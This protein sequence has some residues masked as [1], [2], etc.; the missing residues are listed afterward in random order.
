VTG[1]SDG[2]VSGVWKETRK[3]GNQ[4][5]HYTDYGLDNV[6]LEGMIQYECQKCGWRRLK[7]PDVRA[8]HFLIAVNL[9]FKMEPLTRHEIGYLMRII[10]EKCWRTVN[11]F[12]DDSYQ[13]G[14]MIF[15]WTGEE[16]RYL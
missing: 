3:K 15:R 13:S 4:G 2:N 7:I 16:W 8:L 1:N 6:Y 5:F 11:C 12:F 10:R 14:P 9:V